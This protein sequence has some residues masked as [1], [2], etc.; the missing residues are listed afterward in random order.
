[1]RKSIR[2][3][4]PIKAARED[5]RDKRSLVSLRFS[6]VTNLFDVTEIEYALSPFLVA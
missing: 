2:D 1:M 3:P 5:H 6:I 4:L